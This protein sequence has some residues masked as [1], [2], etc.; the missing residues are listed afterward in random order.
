MRTT[1]E[2]KFKVFDD[3][4][5]ILLQLSQLKKEVQE[6]VCDLIAKFNKSLYKIPTMKRP[7]NENKKGFFM[8]SMPPNIIFHVRRNR[9]IDVDAI[10]RLVMDLEDDLLAARKWRREM[11]NPQN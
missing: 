5:T 7:N 10:Q 8:N 11:Q 1:F 4:Y 6:S 2:S 9:V 3:E